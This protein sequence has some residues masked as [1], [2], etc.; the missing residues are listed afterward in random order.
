MTKI[1]VLVMLAIITLSTYMGIGL[2][3][4]LNG[5]AICK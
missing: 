1:G 4:E 3:V 5:I 2:Y